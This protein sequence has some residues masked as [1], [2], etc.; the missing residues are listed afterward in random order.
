MYGQEGAPRVTAWSTLAT[1][2]PAGVVVLNEAT[3]RGYS[4]RVNDQQSA[5]YVHVDD[6]VFISSNKTDA[7]HCDKLLDMTVAGLGAVGFQLTQQSRDGELDKVVGYEVVSKP[8][9]F[10]LPKKKMVML[11]AALMFLAEQQTVSVAVLR[12][13]L[14]MWIFGALLRRDLLSIPHGVFRFI[15]R[16][17]DQVVSWWPVARSEVR[18]MAHVIPR[19]GVSCGLTSFELAFL[20]R[21]NGHK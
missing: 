13:L 8:A 17:E 1:S 15:E 19:D 4:V 7:L 14:G 6:A 21:C 18:A 20:N 5:A 16:Y 2:R 10:R 12:S 9:A 11:R 3:A